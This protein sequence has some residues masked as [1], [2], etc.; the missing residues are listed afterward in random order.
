MAETNIE[1]KNFVVLVHEREV[2]DFHQ[3]VDVAIAWNNSPGFELA[4]KQIKL[5][6][7]IEGSADEYREKYL[8]LVYEIG[9]LNIKG[10]SVVERLRIE[11]DFSFW[12]LTLFGLRRWNDKS[13]TTETIK[14]IALETELKRLGANQVV[15]AGANRQVEKCI[16]DLCLKNSWTF[17]FHR[18]ST[19]A[20]HVAIRTKSANYY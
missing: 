12:W 8:K 2:L 5:I 4:S 11:H 3:K 17:T 9:S 6:Q 19:T 7:V 15:F 1:T 20:H 18:P 14:L 13:G 16:R 10:K